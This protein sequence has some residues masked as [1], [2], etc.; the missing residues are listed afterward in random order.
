LKPLLKLGIA[1]TH[2]SAIWRNHWPNLIA[3][4][5]YPDETRKIIYATNAVES[6]NSVIR[7]ATNA[8]KIFPSDQSAM[9]VIY[10]TI[11]NTS[12]KWSMPLRDWKPAINQLMFVY[13][14]RMP[15]F[16]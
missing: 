1:N 9:K 11:E 4:F 7:K 15:I 8:R 13:Q 12:K 5:D 10:L 6:V 2:P 14:D 3:F 16:I